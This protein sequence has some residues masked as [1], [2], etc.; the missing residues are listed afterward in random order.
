[1]SIINDALKKVQQSLQPSSSNLSDSGQP[2]T[3]ATGPQQPKMKDTPSG[4]AQAEP[5]QT[6]PV[7]KNKKW[8]DSALLLICFVICALLFFLILFL[9]RQKS[10]F[11][12]PA[13]APVQK[14]AAPTP[15]AP[16]KP[17]RNPNDIVVTGVMK[18]GSG[19]M[20]LINNEI[21]EVGEIVNGARIVTIEM[22]RVEVMKDG[23]IQVLRVSGK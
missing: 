13:P 1:M 16:N 3:P 19:N 14:T 21:Y 22:D 5:Q 18:M 2:P 11:P 8:R 6:H 17:P 7:S 23:Q 12:M 20:A 4:T 10:L 15:P 9:F